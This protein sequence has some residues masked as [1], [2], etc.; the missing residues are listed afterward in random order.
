M[1]ETE[2]FGQ[3]VQ[4]MDLR[5][6]KTREAIFDAFFDLLNEYHF[7]QISVA[8]LIDKAR[9]GRSTFYSHFA[10]KDDLLTAVTEQLFQ[11]VFESSSYSEHMSNIQNGED[12]SLLDLLTHLFQHFKENEAKITTLFKLEDAYFSRSLTTQLY[13]YLVPLV[14]PLYF[15][16]SGAMLPES[17]IHQHIAGTF[18]TCLNWWL[19]QKNDIT[20]RAI[21]FYYLQLLD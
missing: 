18:T 12:D 16:N 2:Q 8:K 13:K 1:S 4:K 11:H 6:Q 21:S 14:Q 15:D 17:L 20:A 9:I 7:H 19:T 5:T 3:I 10:S